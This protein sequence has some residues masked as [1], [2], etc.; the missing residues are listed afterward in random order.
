MARRLR[1]QYPGAMYHVMNRGDQREAIFRDDEDRQRFLSTLGEACLKT[2]WQVHAYCR[3]FGLLMD[4]RRAEES[5]ASYEALR[6]DWVLGSEE[7]RRELLGAAV[8]RLGANHYGVE[9]RETQVQK[10]ERLETGGRG[11]LA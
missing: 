10:A 3:Q 7:F 11:H 2:E 9:R 6:R 1:I 4:K 5:A 8:E